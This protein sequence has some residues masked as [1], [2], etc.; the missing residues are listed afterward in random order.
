MGHPETLLA[1][2][3]RIVARLHPHWITLVPAAFWCVVVLGAVGVGIAFLPS[4]S[5]HT[6]LLIA[7]L[8]LGLLLLGRL[9]LL[10]LARWRTAYWV[11]TTQRVQVRRGV[12]RR[13]GRDILLPHIHDVASSQS[14]WERLVAAGTI[15]IES[16][17]EHG[18]ETLR[19][20]RRPGRVQQL[21]RRLIEEDGE[22]RTREGSAGPGTGSR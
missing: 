8:V 3:E 7:L 19:D 10:P 1:D 13:V 6:P 18:K 16:G 15:T 14:F 12:L 22:R 11:F 5:P 4:G 2:D 17:G 20:V 9:T 21:L